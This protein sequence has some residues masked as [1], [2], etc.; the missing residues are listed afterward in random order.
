VKQFCGGSS[1]N[2]RMRVRSRIAATG[3]PLRSTTSGSRRPALHDPELSR[4]LQWYFERRYGKSEGPGTTPFYCD[5]RRVG[6]FAIAP[7]ELARADENALFRLF[8]GLSMYQAVRD[9]V[10]MQHQHRLPISDVNILASLPIVEAFVTS[11]FCPGAHRDDWITHYCD[12]WKRSDLVD[13]F[14]HPGLPCAVK[15][16]TYAFNRMGDIGKLPS[17]AYVTIWARGGLAAALRMAVHTTPS[18]TT[19]ASLLVGR[20][21]QVHRVGRKLATLF[22]SVLSTPA[23]YP[24]LSPWF[25]DIDGNDLVVVDTNVARAVDCL[26]GSSRARTYESREAWVRQQALRL[27][28][29]TFDPRIPSYSPRMLQQALYAFCSRSNRVA[30]GDPCASARAGCGTCVPRVCP[31]S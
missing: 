13:C 24:D 21:S 25:P 10:V 6:A 2:R 18:P 22:V 29:S 9:T 17:S 31:F 26:A 28:L 27:N 8:I 16:A 19:R 11:R 3:Y 20:L 4:I 5:P 12:V 14:K 30:L 7:D 15:G 1:S 23:L